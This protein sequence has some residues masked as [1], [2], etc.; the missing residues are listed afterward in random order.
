MNTL[1]A[2]GEAPQPRIALIAD[3][4][5]ASAAALSRNLRAAQ[6]AVTAAC[7]DVST[8]AATARDADLVIIDLDQTA[9]DGI[10]LIRAIHNTSDAPIIVLSARHESSRKVAA[11]DSGAVDYVTKPFGIDEL[12]A[13]MR[14]HTRRREDDDRSRWVISTGSLT[15][16]LSAKRVYRDRMPVRLTPI[17]WSL[18]EILV[19]HRGQLVTQRQLL[20][21]IWG[22]G[23]LNYSH[24]LRVH[25]AHLRQKLEED[26]AHPVHIR[27]EPGMGY[28]FDG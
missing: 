22:P 11:L 20:T 12:L 2:S 6:W 7:G 14:A 3:G 8:E 1:L 19:R 9:A 15:I 16:D 10:K 26:P 21:E 23:Y 27:T 25:S 13:R 5:S 4:R 17:E 18:L 28:R 24:Y